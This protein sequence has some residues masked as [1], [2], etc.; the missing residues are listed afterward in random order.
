VIR[1]AGLLATRD[2]GRDFEAG[3]ELLIGGIEKLR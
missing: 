2:P 3:L 1:L